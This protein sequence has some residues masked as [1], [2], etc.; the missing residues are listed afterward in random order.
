MTVNCLAMA[1]I[2]IV[3]LLKNR[4]AAIELQLEDPRDFKY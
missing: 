4:R 3:T 1:T 2:K